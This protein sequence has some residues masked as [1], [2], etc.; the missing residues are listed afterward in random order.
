MGTGWAGRNRT[1][2]ERRMNPSRTPAL[3]EVTGSAALG[4][5]PFFRGHQAPQGL[6]PAPPPG[7][8]PGSRLPLPAYFLPCVPAKGCPAWR[9]REAARSPRAA[10][11]RPGA[12]RGGTSETRA[13][14]MPR[15]VPEVPRAGA[16]L[17][18][19][20]RRGF[21]AGRRGRAG[22]GP[23]AGAAGVRPRPPRP[24]PRPRQ[25]SGPAP[26]R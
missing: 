2:H 25:V 1:P 11:N 20:A 21:R 4:R 16:G 8:V 6:W 26:A 18:R 7:Q 23:R 10:A 14:A 22:P 15:A 19:A 3:C 12:L 17:A 24:R 13:S 5:L 9:C